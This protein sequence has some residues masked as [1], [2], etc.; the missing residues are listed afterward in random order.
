MFRGG[1][2]QHY[3]MMRRR[4]LSSEQILLDLATRPADGL[5]MCSQLENI[6][7]G[8][9][10]DALLRASQHPE[11]FE[12]KILIDV[13]D[14]LKTLART[15]P[16]RVH[17]QH[18]DLLVGVAGLLASECKVWWSKPFQVEAEK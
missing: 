5:R 17:R 13:Q 3:E 4:A 18:Y 1:L 15:E 16:E 6:V 2:A 11:P 14:R 12:T 9:C 10:D 8:E 7:L